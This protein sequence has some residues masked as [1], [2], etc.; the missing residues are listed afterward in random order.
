MLLFHSSH[1]HAEVTGLDDYADALRLNYLLNGF[2]DLCREAFLNLQTTRKEFDQA[3]NFTEPDHLSIR[4]I[5]DVHFAEEWKHVMFA[6]AEH[7]NVFDDDHLVVRHRE[8]GALEQ[9]LGI[10]LIALG[11]V[12]HCFVDALRGGGETFAYRIFAQTNQ[13]FA[14]QVFETGAGHRRIFEFFV[15]RRWR[16]RIG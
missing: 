16:H 6:E 7:L 9:G 12:L 13:H 2:G 4:D 3:W 8:Q 11:Q 1:H 15:K 5:S 14:N 10:F